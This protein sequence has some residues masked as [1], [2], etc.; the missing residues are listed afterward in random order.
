MKE[1]NKVFAKYAFPT[2][3]GM[4]VTT[5]YTFVDGIF[6]GNFVGPNAIASIGIVWPFLCMAM[7]VSI[8]IATGGGALVSINFG[9]GNKERAQHLFSQS[10]TAAFGF[11]LFFSFLCVVFPR[12]IA[13]VLGANEILIDGCAVYIRWFMLFGIFF[14]MAIVLNTFVN[15]DKNPKLALMGMISGCVT[16]IFLDYLFVYVFKWGLA[17]AAIA[18]GLGQV[19]SC[20]TLYTHFLLKKGEL[21]FNFETPVLRDIRKIMVTG[22]PV[23]I[24]EISTPLATVVYNYVIIRRMG[25]T[26]V[27]AFSVVCYL[28]T[29]YFCVFSGIAQGMQPPVSR[30]Y[31][32]KRLDMVK[33]I[34]GSGIMCAIFISVGLYVLMFVFSRQ[35]I[36]MFTD[37]SAVIDI[38]VT[39]LRIYGLFSFFF[40][41]NMIIISLF[42][43]T[44]YTAP[45]SVISGCKCFLFN[46]IFVLILPYIFGNNGIWIAAVVGEFCTFALAYLQYKLNAK[47]I[48]QI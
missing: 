35:A 29:I 45:A 6:V 18:S 22:V 13:T 12:H 20:I 32:E 46:I 48:F 10:I 43:A 11:L 21:K 27:A 26:G 42:Q 31:G 2:V 33:K 39:S 36:S 8:M 7:A 30:Y 34:F 5:L 37:N 38:A 4:L 40:A 44:R 15:N 19:V 9:R 23:F 28:L 1:Y 16:N 24:N 25:E 3:M 14:G 17:G 47:K 41:V